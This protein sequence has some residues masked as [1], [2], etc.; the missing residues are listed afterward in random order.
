MP[1]VSALVTDGRTK[2]SAVHMNLASL[3]WGAEPSRRTRSA[4]A[5]GVVIVG[6][7]HPPIILRDF[8]AERNDVAFLSEFLQQRAAAQQNGIGHDDSFRP[9]QR[10]AHQ[11][12]H[13]PPQSGMRNDVRMVVHD[14]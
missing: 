11:R 12:F 5:F 9:A 3:A 14:Q 7:L 2:T 13:K 8:D 10:P 4:T 1:K 6:A